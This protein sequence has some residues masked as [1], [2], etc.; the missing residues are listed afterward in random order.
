MLAVLIR[1]RF[2]ASKVLKNMA[3]IEGGLYL[4]NNANII[5]GITIGSCIYCLHS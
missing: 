3:I 1:Y 2:Y 4:F 5:K